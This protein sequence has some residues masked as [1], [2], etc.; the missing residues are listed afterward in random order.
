MAGVAPKY[1]MDLIDVIEKT[2]SMYGTS[3]SKVK[4]DAQD[5]PVEP[6]VIKKITIEKR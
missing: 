2:G 5:K 3:E 6:V 4:T 1:V